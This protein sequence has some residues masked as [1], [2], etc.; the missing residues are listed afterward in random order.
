[1]VT[2]FL[3]LRF[4]GEARDGAGLVFWISRRHR[5]L[6][7][8][9]CVFFC[10]IFHQRCDLKGLQIDPGLMPLIHQSVSSSRFVT[11]AS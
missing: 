7:C 1:M 2:E 6:I 11:S 8:R 4:E 10:T 5:R 9:L 3:Y